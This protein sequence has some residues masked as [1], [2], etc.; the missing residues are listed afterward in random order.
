MND[1]C[2]LGGKF[3]AKGFPFLQQMKN[4]TQMQKEVPYLYRFFDVYSYFPSLLA[5]EDQNH[6]STLRESFKEAMNARVKLPKYI[7]LFFGHHWMKHLGSVQDASRM[8]D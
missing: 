8:L 6:L 3:L 1:I 5:V 7:L 4:E 2:L